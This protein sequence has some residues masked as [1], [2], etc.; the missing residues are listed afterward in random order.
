MPRILLFNPRFQL[1]DKKL[2]AG[3]YALFTI[4]GKD[5]W[6]IVFNNNAK[7]WGCIYL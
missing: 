7:Q 3:T 1:K 4:P 6:T 2:P 5:E